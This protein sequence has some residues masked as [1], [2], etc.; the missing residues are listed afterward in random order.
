MLDPDP[1]DNRLITLREAAERLA[2]SE[3]T[4]RTLIA[5]GQLRRLRI[6]RAVRIDPSDLC[7]FI[8]RLKEQRK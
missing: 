5:G 6:G 3:R 2:V 1:V 8:A 4:V 7:A